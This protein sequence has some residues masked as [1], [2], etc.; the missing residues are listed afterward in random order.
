MILRTDMH[1]THQA[2]LRILMV[3][4]MLILLTSFACA[5][6]TDMTSTDISGPSV[7]TIDIEYPD[8]ITPEISWQH[9]LGKVHSNQSYIMEQ[10][11]DGGYVV[12][13]RSEPDAT[14]VTVTN[15]ND[16]FWMAKLSPAGDI[17]WQKRPGT[18]PSNTLTG[19]QQPD[20]CNM[21]PGERFE[22]YF[23]NGSGTTDSYDTWMGKF[24]HDG[25]LSWEK[26][27]QGILHG[28][29]HGIRQMSDG[30]YL[31]VGSVKSR[32]DTNSS[33]HG[34]LDYWVVRLTPSGDLSW[35]K[36]F[37]GSKDDLGYNAWQT[38]DGGYIIAGASS[39]DDGHV[40][41]NHGD[42]DYWIVKLTPD[43]HLSWATSLGGAD[44][45]Q[46]YAI[47][48]TAD[49]G[50]IIAG[51]SRSNDGDVT[52]NHGDFD[53]WIV[54]LTPAG[55]ISWEQS[56][57]GTGNDEAHSIMQTRDG[58]FII[59]GGS[60]SWNGDVTGNHGNFDYWVVKLAPDG[61]MKWQKSLGGSKDDVGQSIMQTR[62]G[63]YLLSGVSHS[64]DG[65]IAG[66]R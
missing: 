48:Q 59:A 39:S 63:G 65:D 15:R 46:P 38:P 16:E 60:E 56:L 3:L 35:E 18:I 54:K 9:C 62:D 31:L 19:T 20:S 6:G 30:G 49:S 43:G 42:L 44:R 13:K 22:P 14:G 10:T 24:T 17:A 8:L 12:L 58:G 41:G 53:F 11:S 50:Y 4:L 28:E 1:N 36:T 32:G 33:D 25:Y 21:S 55:I 29:A 37:G 52:G 2:T 7:Q 66:N 45:D 40:S 61:S 5:V 51:R 26:I 23:V 47:Q 27:L 34:D 57:G 64:D